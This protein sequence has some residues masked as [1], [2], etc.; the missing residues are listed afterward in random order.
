MSKPFAGTKNRVDPL[1][2]T[3][4]SILFWFVFVSMGLALVLY[5][6]NLNPNRTFLPLV[7]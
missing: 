2:A 3:I 7:V 6:S 4:Y 5:K 1:K